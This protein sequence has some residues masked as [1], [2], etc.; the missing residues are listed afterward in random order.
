MTWA[1]CWL[2]GRVASYWGVL[3]ATGAVLCGSSGCLGSSWLQA[4]CCLCRQP[5]PPAQRV[6]GYKRALRACTH[7]CAAFIAQGS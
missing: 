3:I 5:L 4:A 2:L 6:S 7:A 1:C